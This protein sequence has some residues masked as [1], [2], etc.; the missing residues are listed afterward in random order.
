MRALL[1][2]PQVDGDQVPGAG[3]ALELVRSGTLELDS[4][5]RDEVPYGARG[6]DLSGRRDGGDA[7]GDVDGDSGDLAVQQLA[8]AGVNP[9]ANLDRQLVDRRDDRLRTANGAPRPV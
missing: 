2:A 4:R 3:D 7:G 6:Q 5:P 9:C 1:A 8:L